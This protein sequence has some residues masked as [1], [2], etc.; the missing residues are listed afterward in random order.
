MK[1]FLVG[2]LANAVLVIGVAAGLRPGRHQRLRGAGGRPG[3]R[4]T[5][6][7]SVLGVALTGHVGLAFKLGAVP[8]HA[9]LPDVAEGAPAPCGRLPDRRARRSAQPSR[10][11][12]SSRSF[13]AEAFAGRPLVAALAVATMTLGN[14]AR[15]WQDDVRRLL[16]WSSVSQ[17]GYALMAVA[18]VG[19]T[20][21]AVPALLVFLLGYA[22]ANLAAFAAVAHLRGRTALADYAGLWSLARP[23]PPPAIVLAL[24]VAGR[25]P[26]ARRLRRQVHRSSPRRSRAATG[27]SRSRPSPTP[28]PRSSTTCA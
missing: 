13:R 23:G 4:R 5:S 20:P 26:A 14:L 11:R 21:T 25:H 17:A 24:P 27:G 9:W 7:L 19:L 1:Y 6:P 8:A 12:A 10:S 15:F 22:A 3:R 2:A 28:S 18:V 16:G